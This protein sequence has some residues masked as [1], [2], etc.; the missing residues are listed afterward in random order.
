MFAK[1]LFRQNKLSQ[2]FMGNYNNSRFINSRVQAILNSWFDEIDRDIA[3]TEDIAKKWYVP[4]PEFDNYLTQEHLDDLK[5]FKETRGMF[6]ITDD[7]SVLASI[8][9]G[10]QMS[11]N[12]FRNKAEAFETDTLCLKLSKAISKPQF[13]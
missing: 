12:I 1:T 9:L 4:N 7:Q 13:S 3:P 5:N 8:I 6:W 11:R 2:R 10:D